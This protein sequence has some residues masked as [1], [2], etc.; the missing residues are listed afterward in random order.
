MNSRI[1]DI[2]TYVDYIFFTAI[3]FFA[4][5]FNAEHLILIISFAFLFLTSYT[6]RRNIFYN[7]RLIKET[8]LHSDVVI[9]KKYRL[10]H[11]A[12]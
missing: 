11:R 2:L 4:S 7:G 5:I 9:R 8:E 3:L 10:C 6:L 12:V 1:K